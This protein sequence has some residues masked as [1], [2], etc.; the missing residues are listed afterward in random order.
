MASDLNANQLWQV[1]LAKANE[2]ILRSSE[3]LEEAWKDVLLDG[4]DFR[5]I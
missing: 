2:D 4:L 1:L 5:K 3:I